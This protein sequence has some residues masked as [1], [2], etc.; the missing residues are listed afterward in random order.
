ML[1]P[2]IPLPMMTTSAISGKERVERWPRSSG[3][4]SLCQKD[5]VDSGL[6]RSHGFLCV[7]IS[8]R[9]RGMFLDLFLIDGD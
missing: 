1:A 6:G 4:G 9:E 3:E 2:V 5:C 7:G 8:G